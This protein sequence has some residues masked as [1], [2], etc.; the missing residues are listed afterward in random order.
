MAGTWRSYGPHGYGPHR[1]PRARSPWRR[2]LPAPYVLP[3]GFAA[4]LAVGTVAA[5]LHGR[6]DATGVLICCAVVVGAL[7][8]VSEPTAA[9]PL[10][11]IGWLTA[12]GFSRPPYADLRLTGTVASRAAIT[13]AVV[14]VVGSRRRRGSA[15]VVRAGKTRD[16]G[17]TARKR[18]RSPP[19]AGRRRDR[20]RRPARADR[21]AVGLPARGS[22]SPTTC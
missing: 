10:A 13:L 17:Q 21:A 16:C 2:G 6:L 7:A 15:A 1:D 8:P 5:G 12:V 11:V 3:A 4:L 18:H 20:G 9:A 14:A 22:T 19:A